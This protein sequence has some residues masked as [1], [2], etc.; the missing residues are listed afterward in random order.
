M[1]NISN[2]VSLTGHLG[3]DVEIITLD[4]GAKIAR[5]S[6]AT[7]NSYTNRQ[8]EK[9]QEVEWHNI[10]AWNRTAELMERLLKKGTRVMIE[11]MLK[12]ETY[13]NKEGVIRYNTKVQINNF[14]KLTAKEDA[15]PF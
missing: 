10:I 15:L 14:Q 8:G 2:S 5:T 11:G 1:Y 6:I 4:S 13:K 12:N 3:K 9:I 7:N